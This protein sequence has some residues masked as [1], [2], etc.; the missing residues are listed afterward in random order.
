MSS[1]DDLSN[2][3]RRY[4]ESARLEDVFFSVMKDDEIIQRI[5]MLVDP[6]SQ[7]VPAQWQKEIERI[8]NEID[9][10]T[11]PPEDKTEKGFFKWV[12]ARDDIR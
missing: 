3:K 11:L 2:F 6:R 7:D 12:M 5:Q 1:S 4:D 10:S 8:H 9:K